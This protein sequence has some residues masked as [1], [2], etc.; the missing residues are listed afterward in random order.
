[1]F[2]PKGA[3]FVSLVIV[4]VVI[5]PLG[6]AQERKQSRPES[7]QAEREAMYYRY[8]EFPSYVKGGSITPHWMADGSSF[9]YA[10]GA[11]DNTVIWKVDPKANIKTPLFDIGRLQ[12]AL[13]PVLGHEP[14]YQGL[15]FA[16]FTFVDGGRRIEFSVE[17]KELILELDTYTIAIAPSLSAEEKKRLVPQVSSDGSNWGNI[18]ELLS[19]DRRWFVGFADHNLYLRS[20]M[21]GRAEPLTRDGI[22]DYWWDSRWA[23]WSPDNRRLAVYKIDYRGGRKIP[24]V[25]YLKPQEEVEWVLNAYF[26]QVERRYQSELFVLD[27]ESKRQV[28]LDLPKKDTTFDYSLEPGWAADG[29][30]LL[31]LRLLARNDKNLVLM[32]A[33]PVTGATREV[34]TDSWKIFVNVNDWSLLQRVFTWLADGKRF[35]WLSERDGWRHLYLY[36]LDGN[37]VRRLTEGSFPVV[38]V[39]AVDEKAGWIYFTAHGDP[40]RPYDTHV[41][42]VNLE[43]KG[44]TQLTEA[45]GRHDIQFSP[46]NQFFVDIHSTVARPPVVELRR[47]D[48][49]LLQTLSKANIDALK[50]L[51]WKPPE[52]FVVKAA[53]GKTDLYGVLYKPYDFDAKKQYP[54]IEVIYG[55]PFTSVVPK[56]FADYRAYYGQAPALAQL[57]FITFLLDARGTPERGKEFQHM[58]Y[59]NMGRHEIPD[60]V[61]A[62]KQLAEKRPYMDLSRVG[63]VGQ[64]RGGYFATRAL[65]LYPDVYHVGVASAGPYEADQIFPEGPPEEIKEAYEYA[66]NLRHAGNLKGKLLL[67]HGTSDNVVPV[68]ETMKMVDALIRTEKSFDLLLMPGQGHSLHRLPGSAPYWREAVRRYFQEHLKP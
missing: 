38:Q 31:F 30:Q 22:E 12:T 53:D 21:D 34:L 54:V 8:L 41:Y 32:A 16:E 1:M 36:D 17:G 66:S 13:T 64:S 58:A 43:G 50:D 55:G 6:S 47:A 57:G 24:L 49:A 37:L 2:N 42:R 19:P 56:S 3:M 46:S 5:A 9:W 61:A 51:M 14:P 18:T 59:P 15:P 68:S 7:G 44:F 62:L 39:L 67:I 20:T 52:E 35:I 65:L 45:T 40:Q 25:H 29:G 11:P 23:K 28:R 26:T 10:E 48:G 33:N 63:I 27:I 60:H 4:L